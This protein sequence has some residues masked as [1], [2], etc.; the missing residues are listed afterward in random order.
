M[1]KKRVL[2]DR[3][4]EEYKLEDTVQ[5]Y[6]YGRKFIPLT[7]EDSAVLKLP[8]EEKSFKLYGFSPEK[9]VKLDYRHGKKTH[10]ILP[11]EVSLFYI[12]LIIMIMTNDNLI[13]IY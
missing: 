5:G 9:F 10:V 8:S 4:R 6:M 13:T 12:L 7:E 1:S 2:A 3:Y 11:L